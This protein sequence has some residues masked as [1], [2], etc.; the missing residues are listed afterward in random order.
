MDR[1]TL[2]GLVMVGCA[3]VLSVSGCGDDGGGEE[4][5]AGTMGG[6]GDGDSCERPSVQ[7][8]SSSYISGLCGDCLCDRCPQLISSCDQD[9][10]DLIVC[11]HKDCDGNVG[12]LDG[13]AAGACSEYAA[14]LSDAKQMAGCIYDPNDV[15]KYGDD[16]NSCYISCNFGVF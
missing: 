11:M 7:G 3:L 15:G 4:N 9:C 8:I 10:Y 5:T 14:G 6:D 1:R 16:R 12:D 13:C 2:V